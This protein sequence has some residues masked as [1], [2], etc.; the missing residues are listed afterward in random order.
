MLLKFRL[1]T[2]EGTSI[3]KYLITHFIDVLCLDPSPVMAASDDQQADAADEEEM[4]TAAAG[5]A[6]EQLARSADSREAARPDHQLIKE[7]GTGQ[8]D[9]KVVLLPG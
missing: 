8:E 2:E 9:K 3:S 6:D 5:S 1:T 7:P 4:A